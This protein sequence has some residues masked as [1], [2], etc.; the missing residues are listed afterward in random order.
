MSEETYEI[1]SLVDGTI[2]SIKSYIYEY[3]SN[4]L[5]K[6]INAYETETHEAFV[7]H[8]NQR[9]NIQI[10]E[11]LHNL[12]ALVRF[13]KESYCPDQALNFICTTLTKAYKHYLEIMETPDP[14]LSFAFE[15]KKLVINF[16]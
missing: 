16:S 15:N 13:L 14:F 2:E 9:I 5:A 8:S 4:S 11:S 6:N 1:A 3:D 10:L 7:V 12:L